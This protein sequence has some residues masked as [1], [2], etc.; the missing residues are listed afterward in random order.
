MDFSKLL[1]GLSKLTHQFLKVFTWIYQIYTWISISWNMDLS[2]LLRGFVK[3]VLCISLLLPNKTKLKFEQDFKA[4]WRCLMNQS[5]QCLGSVVPLAMF[6]MTMTQCLRSW[7]CLEESFTFKAAPLWHLVLFI[8]G[9]PPR[10]A[11]LSAAPCIYSMPA[12]LVSSS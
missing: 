3:V 11:L 12:L 10:N 2:K 4:C 6:T 5:T 9:K 8:G 1:H 7:W